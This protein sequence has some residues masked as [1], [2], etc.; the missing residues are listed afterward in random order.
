[1]ENETQS[2]T[3]TPDTPKQ[4]ADVNNGEKSA[5]IETVAY[6]FLINAVK[7]QDDSIRQ[8]MNITGLILGVYV[9][10]VANNYDK[11]TVADPQSDVLGHG[12]I[13]ITLLSIPAI[14]WMVGLLNAVSALHPTG[15]RKVLTPLS[16]LFYEIPVMPKYEFMREF[17]VKPVM[18]ENELMREFLVKLIERK[19]RLLVVTNFTTLLGL[20]MLFYG[21]LLSGLHIL[22][23]T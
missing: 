7:T 4:F 23:L 1:M 19:Y 22:N 11:I 21:A 17:L 16:H 18:P 20:G 14:I 2:T 10:I 8:V 9:T 6:N 15:H 3:P 12:I 13:R 5:A